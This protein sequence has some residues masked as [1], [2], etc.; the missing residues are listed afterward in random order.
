MRFLTERVAPLIIDGFSQSP[1]AI[2]GVGYTGDTS[3]ETS[4]A[5]CADGGE[6]Q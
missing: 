3:L 4:M 6:I 2:V 5:I 1:M